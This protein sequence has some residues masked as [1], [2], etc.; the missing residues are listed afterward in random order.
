MYFLLIIIGILIIIGSLLWIF[1]PPAFA[2]LFTFV[3]AVSSL[4]GTWLTFK[5]KRTQ[6]ASENASAARKPQSYDILPIS[7]ELWLRQEIP[8]IDIWLYVVNFEARELVIDTL[9]I[10]HFYI[11]SSPDIDKISIGQEVVVPARHWTHAYCCRR[12]I[13]SE[14]RSLEQSLQRGGNLA[15]PNA[16][17]MVTARGHVGRKRLSR[18][19][20]HLSMN[21][22]AMD[23]AGQAQQAQAENK[24]STPE[25][26]EITSPISGKPVKY[27][28][29]IKLIHHETGYSLHSH[30]LNYEHIGTSGQQQVTASFSSDDDDYWIVK[31][32]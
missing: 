4:I 5:Q 13:D 7:F 18:D 1:A 6:S 17:F 9:Q 25:R 10:P 22:W 28:S 12:L 27:G 24:S 15:H 23:I 21:G 16:T 11:Q 19:I 31:G 20:S 29:V 2:A 30:G 14:A 32:S 8:H 26:H 3:G